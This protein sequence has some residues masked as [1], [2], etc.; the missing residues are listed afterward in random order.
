MSTT[1]TQKMTEKLSEFDS[2]LAGTLGNLPDTMAQKHRKTLNAL[3]FAFSHVLLHWQDLNQQVLATETEK[4]EQEQQKA[5]RWLPV[6]N[7]YIKESEEHITKF[8]GK[9]DIYISDL[10]WSRELFYAVVTRDVCSRLKEMIEGGIGYANLHQYVQSN[11]FSQVR[12]LSNSTS[13][14]A[15]LVTEYRVKIWSELLEHLFGR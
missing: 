4:Q 13:S 2:L 15:N 1:Q 8:K 14:T 3:S 6:L 12:S 5:S 9:E 7:A 11:L 10:E